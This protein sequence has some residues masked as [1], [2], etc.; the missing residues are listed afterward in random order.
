MLHQWLKS[1]IRQTGGVGD[2]TWTPGYKA[3]GL[4]ATPRWLTI[5]S[6]IS[7]HIMVRF[8]VSLEF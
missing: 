6:I 2:G 5:G 4:S 3:S 8:V 1:L 7:K